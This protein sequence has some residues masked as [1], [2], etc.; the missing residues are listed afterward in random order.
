RG[1]EIGAGNRHGEYLT[2]G[3]G[4]VCLWIRTDLPS[5]ASPPGPLSRTGEGETRKKRRSLLLF[6]PLRSRR[7]GQG[8]RLRR[9][10]PV[11]QAPTELNNY[12]GS[13]SSGRIAGE[14][15]S[16]RERRPPFVPSPRRLEIP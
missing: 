11:R 4:S 15:L 1:G 12:L 2:P 6:P 14:L 9:A 5:E 7:G 10:Y 3:S 8:V 16:L 13:P